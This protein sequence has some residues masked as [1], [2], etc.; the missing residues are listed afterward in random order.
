MASSW[1]GAFD[2]LRAFG[3][4]QTLPSLTLA[5][6]LRA[7]DEMREQRIL[8]QHILTDHLLGVGTVPTSWT[9]QNRHQPQSQTQQTPMRPAPSRPVPPPPTEYRLNAQS[10]KPTTMPA[11]SVI[12]SLWNRI[13]IPNAGGHESLTADE[14]QQLLDQMNQQE[15]STCRQCD[16]CRGRTQTVFGEGRSTADLMFIG[17]GPG[18]NEDIQGRPF[19]GKASELLE[20]M[21]QAMGFK[22]D[23]VYIANVVKCRPPNNR[24]PQLTEVQAC[25][26]YLL[27]QI[28]IIQPKVI[29]TLGG[30]AAQLMLNTQ[31]GITKIRGDWHTFDALKPDG[32]SIDVMPTFHPAYLLRSYTHDNRK[33][34]WADLQ[35]V[36]ERLGK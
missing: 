35:A 18:Q 36:I 26:G 6:S 1:K 22:R 3:I 4:N 12:E 30:P 31:L 9:P 17:E 2:A 10:P 25:G 14:K 5:G 15:V 27:R 19:V 32:P 7:M 28:A 11:T 24:T 16:L 23:E 34:V 29:V 13:S 8:R 21:I 20:K 33:K